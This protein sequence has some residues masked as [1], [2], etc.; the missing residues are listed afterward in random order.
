MITYNITFN[1]IDLHVKNKTMT[2]LNKRF[3]EVRHYPGTNISANIDLGRQAT[4]INC[5]L[6][7]YNQDEKIL[8]EQLLS[9]NVLGDLYINGEGRFYKDVIHSGSFEMTQET[10]D[11]QIYSASAK[12][13][14]LDPFPYDIDT[15]EVMY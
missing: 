8:M 11:G 13:I 14:A 6:Y 4:E 12:F 2:I 3:K 7:A 5:E 1:E 9:T 10:E 15:G